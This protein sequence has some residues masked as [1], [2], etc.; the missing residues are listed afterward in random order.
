V[1]LAIIGGGAA[2]LWA[3]ICAGLAARSRP[4]PTP[5]SIAVFE[6]GP[7]PGVKI[8]MSGGTRCNVTH[9]VVR[10]EDYYGANPHRVS[11]VLRAHPPERTREIFA[12]SLELDLKEED[13]GRI[14][15]RDDR[16]QS[17]LEALL[18][19]LSRAGVPLLRGRRCRRI[20]REEN[21]WRIGFDTPSGTA[22]ARARRIILATGGCSYPQ[23]GSDGLGLRIAETLGHRLVPPVPALTPLALSGSLHGNLAGVSCPAVLRLLA[24]GREERRSSGPLLWTHRGVSGP[25]VLD[26]SGAWSRLRR[27]RPEAAVEVVAGFGGARPEELEA[28]WKTAAV[29]GAATLRHLLPIP[30]RMLSALAQPLGLSPSDRLAQIPRELRREF[31]AQ[32]T[33]FPLPVTGVLG[34]KKAEVTSGGV[35]LEE[36]DQ[37]LESRAAPGVHLCG[38]MLHVDGRMGGFNFQWAWSSASVAA[39]CAVERLA[40]G[41]GETA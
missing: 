14:F 11:K 24:D 31:I 29:S 9:R 35:P 39:E 32:V 4:S 12:T 2:G 21:H 25:A 28:R 15:P 3:G 34:F 7:R 6:G 20:D 22:E 38:E 18:T 1:D 40:A 16:A 13:D 26:L 10:A 19:G 36:L 5:L 30:E 17:V 37:G 23:T 8:L 27:D 33:R 41:S